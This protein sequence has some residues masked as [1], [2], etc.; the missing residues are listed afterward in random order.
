MPRPAQKN[1]VGLNQMNI[2]PRKLSRWLKRLALNLLALAVATFI[3]AA[4]ISALIYQQGLAL[5]KPQVA[6][7][8]IGFLVSAILTVISP[9]SSFKRRTVIL[10]AVYIVDI[11][12]AKSLE[13]LW[14]VLAYFHIDVPEDEQWP[15]VSMVAI[16]ASSIGGY[17]MLG[18]SNAVAN[19]ELQSGSVLARP[20]PRLIARLIDI[21]LINLMVSFAF[22]YLTSRYTPELFIAMMDDYR[23]LF[24]II[25][26]P[27]VVLLIACIMAATGKTLGK[28]ILGIT[29]RTPSGGVPAYFS[30]E[31]RFW[32]SGLAMGLPLFAIFTFIYQYRLVVSG[33][34]ASYDRNRAVVEGKPS[35]SRLA[36]GCL[37][38]A[39]ILSL[40]FSLS[41][42]AQIGD[43][44]VRGIAPWTNPISNRTAYIARTWSESELPIENGRVFHFVSD[45][46]LAEAI[47]GYEKLDIDYA[48]SLNYA[49]AIADVLKSEITL[50]S[51]WA[52]ATI[53][54]HSALRATG[55]SLKR[56]DTKVEIVVAI[57]DRNAWRVLLFTRGRTPDQLPDKEF[58]VNEL[59]GTAN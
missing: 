43:I 31:F 16:V 20:W 10:S 57:K 6:P 45:T 23:P 54:G 22:G 32:F 15:Y 41:L 24:N 19:Q 9:S 35:R 27:I 48:D 29:V 11:A 3:G 25:T 44:N 47:F 58:F 21:L 51:L 12:I 46:L 53:R 42:I 49:H 18:R 2:Q 17:W 37:T 39:L 40:N 30:R 52:P 59:L 33:A 8:L 5:D 55:Q 13:L 56:S 28:A 1:R 4:A 14:P 34:P 7:F 38:I 26:A 50:T 36:A